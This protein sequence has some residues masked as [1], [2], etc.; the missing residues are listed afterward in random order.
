MNENFNNPPEEQ[1]SMDNPFEETQQEVPLTPE[2]VGQLEALAQAEQGELTTEIVSDPY[3]I[4]ELLAYAIANDMIV[5]LSYNKLKDNTSQAYEVEPLEIKSH[6]SHPGG[7]LWVW[8]I[9]A[10]RLK[11]FLLGQIEWAQL[12]G[13]QFVRMIHG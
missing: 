1:P 4:A 8:D 7:Y 11:S 6:G 12:T 10:Q 5:Y 9:T 3:K 2:Q 13:Q